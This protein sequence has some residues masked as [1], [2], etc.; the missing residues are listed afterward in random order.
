MAY[1]KAEIYL[2]ELNGNYPGSYSQFGEDGIIDACFDV[3]G[4]HNAWCF[5]VGAC[6]GETLSNTLWFRFHR[7]WHAVLAEADEL[8][9]SQLIA[10]YGDRYHCVHETVT[11]VDELLSRFDAPKHIDL[12]S[13][14]VDGQDYWLWHDMVEFHPR[15]VCIEYNPYMSHNGQP[16]NDF[17]V[18][19]GQKGQT[20]ANPLIQLGE[21]RGYT[22]AARTYCNLIFVRLLE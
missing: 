14:D 11:D 3:I 6:N 13:I 21:S 16:N 7:G 5:E 4:V 10:K 2:P 20:A 17:M 19:R 15:V 9:A 1:P 12:V 22:L 8:L 18:A